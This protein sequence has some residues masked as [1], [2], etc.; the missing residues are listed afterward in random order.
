[1]SLK[2]AAIAKSNLPHFNNSLKAN[3]VSSRQVAEEFGKKHFHV[4]RDIDNLLKNTPNDFHKSNFGFVEKSDTYNGL[5]IKVKSPE[6]HM[7]KDGF[8]LLVMGYTGKKAMVIRISYI[9]TFNL[10]EQTLNNEKLEDQKA[11]AMLATKEHNRIFTAYH[12]LKSEMDA[13]IAQGVKEGLKNHVHHNEYGKKIMDRVDKLINGF[14]VLSDE[15]TLAIKHVLSKNF[16]P[17]LDAIE[18]NLNA[19]KAAN[20]QFENI[21]INGKVDREREVDNTVQSLPAPVPNMDLV[22]PPAKKPLSDNYNILTSKGIINGKFQHRAKVLGVPS[23]KDYEVFGSSYEYVYKEALAALESAIKSA[24]TGSVFRLIKESGKHGAVR[25]EMSANCPYF[26][27]LNDYGKTGVLNGLKAIGCIHYSW[28]G[29]SRKAWV[30][31]NQ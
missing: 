26:N 14:A 27:A 23:L 11:K 16:T 15:T 19:A 7:T 12:S 30:L 18:K 17:H 25:A 24:A 29:D 9:K 20:D 22:P 2:K 21:L 4:L 3:A 8:I 10:M 31:A 5:G 1:M 6:Y 28:T 13:K